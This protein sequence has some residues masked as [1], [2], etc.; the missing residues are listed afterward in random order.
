[1]TGRTRRSKDLSLPARCLSQRADVVK[2][3]I[4]WALFGAVKDP[5][6]KIAAMV[7]LLQNPP[8]LRRCR[9]ASFCAQELVEDTAWS[10]GALRPSTQFGQ[11]SQLAT[12]ESQQFLAATGALGKRLR[13]HP[14]AESNDKIGCS[15][16]PC[17][18]GTLGGISPAALEPGLNCGE[19]VAPKNSLPRLLVPRHPFAEWWE[20]ALHL[21]LQLGL[22]VLRSVLN[23]SVRQAQSAV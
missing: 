16:P 4:S 6:A 22:L 20:A 5:L 3:S 1:M 21:L 2:L 18:A 11:A 15:S 17:C 12:A 9:A 13:S 23:A 8:S 14:W 7:L 19:V 10:P